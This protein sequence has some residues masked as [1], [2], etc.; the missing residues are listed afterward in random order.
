MEKLN[1]DAMRQIT[2]GVNDIKHT[3]AMNTN[4]LALKNKKDEKKERLATGLKVNSAL[5]N[6]SSFFTV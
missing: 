2:G 1:N 4:L 6:P 5:D 3:A